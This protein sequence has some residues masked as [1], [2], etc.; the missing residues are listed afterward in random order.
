[1]A[2]VLRIDPETLPRTLALDPPV[3]D[4]EFEEMCRGNRM[5]IR[6]ER[7]KDGV[8]RMNLPTGGWTSSA[9]AVITG[10]IG[11]WQ[12]AHERGR[13]FASCVAFCLPDGS[14][15]SPDASYVSEERL[16]TLPKGGLRGFPRVCPDFVIELVSESDPLQKVKDKMN[17]WIANG[18][19][20]AWLIDPYQRQVLV[21][22]PG[23]DAELISGDCI[24]GEGPVN[25]LVL[26]LARIW[27][28][29]ED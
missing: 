26:D 21:F 23:R 5:G 11:N 12:V 18:A 16:K 20:L 2:T 8:V 6:L 13:A 1:M 27:Q 10:Q 28:C 15:L 3:T 29:Y 19:Q 14:I 25:G 24:A 7:T 9:N 4:A 17:D 22:R